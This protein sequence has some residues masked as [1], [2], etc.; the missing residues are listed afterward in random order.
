MGNKNGHRDHYGDGYAYYEDGGHHGGGYGARQEKVEYVEMLDEGAKNDSTTYLAQYPK[1]SLD[2]PKKDKNWAFYNDEITNMGDREAA[3]VSDMHKWF[4]NYEKLERYH[5]YI[6]WLFPLHDPSLFNK[7]I[8]LLQRHEVRS[9][10][11]DKNASARIVRSYE[12]MLDFFGFRLTNKTTGKVD[13]KIDPKSLPD[14]WEKKY[15]M[16]EGRSF[17]R[18]KGSKRAQLHPPGSALAR[19]ESLNTPGNHNFRRISRILKCLGEMGYAH[20]QL[21]FLMRLAEEIYEHKTLTEASKSFQSYWKVFLIGEKNRRALERFLRRVRGEE[22][23]YEDEEAPS[24][25]A[26]DNDASSESEPSFY[27]VSQT[28]TTLAHSSATKTTGDDSDMLL[29]G[30]DIAIRLRGVASTGRNW[31]GLYKVDQ[32]D[33][34]VGNR[35]LAIPPVPGTEAFRKTKELQSDIALPPVVRQA[36][37]LQRRH[38]AHFVPQIEAGRK[39]RMS[40]VKKCEYGTHNGMSALV[41]THPNEKTVITPGSTFVFRWIAAPYAPLIFGGTDVEI[42]IVRKKPRS[43]T[44]ITRKVDLLGGSYAWDV[45][46]DYETG[47]NFFICIRQSNFGRDG[48]HLE[49]A[50]PTRGDFEIRK[51]ANASLAVLP[52]PVALAARKSSERSTSSSGGGSVDGTKM[53]E[54]PKIL[55]KC[56]SDGAANVDGIDGSMMWPGTRGPWEPGCAYEFRYFDSGWDST[57]DSLLFVPARGPVATSRTFKV[58]SAPVGRCRVIK[59]IAPP[60][61]PDPKELLSFAWKQREPAHLKKLEKRKKAEEDVEFELALGLRRRLTR[62]K[63]L[64]RGRWYAGDFEHSELDAKGARRFAVQCDQDPLGTLTR[65]D[66]NGLR[67]MKPRREEAYYYY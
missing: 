27:L 66:F 17:Y 21:P 44:F 12:M 63:V 9:I 51:A 8:Q 58:P 25:S 59:P 11:R 26:A 42:V 48:R 37:A 4:G 41:I 38:I 29:M 67:I 10:R 52:P 28:D 36:L 32:P 60:A 55:R 31:V 35:A 18:K 47:S 1:D 13:R 6:Q 62:V 40:R 7:K 34:T 43:V 61:P 3:K 24:K 53:P 39:I 57:S 30:K 23:D 50:A 64:Y 33:E 15:S 2:D 19:L 45:P 54:S 46:K 49:Y 5:D 14:G 20:Y 65:C 22:E 56:S 16:L